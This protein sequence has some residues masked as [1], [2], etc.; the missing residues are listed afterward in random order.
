MKKGPLTKSKV[1]K[2]TNGNSSDNIKTNLKIKSD[3]NTA[4]ANSNSS[5]ASQFLNNIIVKE[6][7]TPLSK[8]KVNGTASSTIVDSIPKN[9][10]I[11]KAIEEAEQ[12][13]SEND[14][15]SSVEYLSDSDALFSPLSTSNHIDSIGEEDMYDFP[16]SFD[17][18]TLR[19]F[20]NFTMTHET[21]YSGNNFAPSLPLNSTGLNIIDS[22]QYGLDDLNSPLA[23][24]NDDFWKE[25]HVTSEEAICFSDRSD[26]SNENFSLQERK[27]SV[28]SQDLNRNNFTS[29]KDFVSEDLVSNATNSKEW[30]ETIFGETKGKVKLL[31]YRD[32]DG[33][34]ALKIRNSVNNNNNPHSSLLTNNCNTNSTDRAGHATT[35]MVSKKKRR[36]KKSKLLKKAIRRKSGVAQMISTNATIGEFML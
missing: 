3:N 24:S 32:A 29:L 16:S 27:A 31:C 19:R 4:N 1:S 36:S 23:E 20:Q 30:N 34:L 35:G 5:K 8:S 33:T 9:K 15:S 17:D 6:D 13:G 21:D 26:T 22:E 10:K 28:I 14:S 2:S 12:T 11:V 7:I 25:V 18:K